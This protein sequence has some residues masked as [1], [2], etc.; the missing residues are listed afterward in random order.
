MRFGVG[1]VCSPIAYTR[2]GDGDRTDTGHHLAFRQVNV[3]HDAWW[4]S[5]SRQIGML[6]EKVATSASG[7]NGANSARASKICGG[8]NGHVSLSAP[9]STRLGKLDNRLNG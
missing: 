4:P 8:I 2:L 3:A 9:I 1:S 6:A 5:A 7:P